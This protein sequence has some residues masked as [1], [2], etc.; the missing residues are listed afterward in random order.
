MGNQKKKKIHAKNMGRPDQLDWPPRPAC[1]A[2]S[3]YTTINSFGAKVLSN[4]YNLFELW[5][6][7]EC[8]LPSWTS[9]MR[10]S[11]Y[12]RRIESW[13]KEALQALVVD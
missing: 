13:N 4:I 9:Q 10:I 8:H 11:R 3:N 6:E 5:H 1:F 7:Q 12:I 2:T